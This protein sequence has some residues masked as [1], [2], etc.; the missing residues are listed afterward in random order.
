MFSK[1]WCLDTLVDLSVLSKMIAWQ[2]QAMTNLCARWV[3]EKL[4]LVREAHG[5][6]VQSENK[7]GSYLCRGYSGFP[8]LL[9]QPAALLEV[10][11]YHGVPMCSQHLLLSI[12][13]SLENTS[14]NIL[15][16]FMR[17][18]HLLM[19]SDMEKI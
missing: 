7:E 16:L 10:G 8:I 5:S 9:H 12:Y 2:I 1:K 14:V 13:M 15:I 19:L 4:L 3:T 17:P 6:H 18:Y 11:K